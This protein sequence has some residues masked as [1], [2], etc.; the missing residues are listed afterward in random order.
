[1]IMWKALIKLLGLCRLK[2]AESSRMWVT[3]K[4]FW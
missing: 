3:E 2:E 1:M 4:G